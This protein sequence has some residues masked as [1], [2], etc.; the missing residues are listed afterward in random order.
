MYQDKRS[1]GHFTLN[2]QID[3]SPWLVSAPDWCQ[4]RVDVRPGTG[5]NDFSAS[6]FCCTYTRGIYGLSSV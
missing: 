1:P 5:N 3:V 6:R 2:L 4:T